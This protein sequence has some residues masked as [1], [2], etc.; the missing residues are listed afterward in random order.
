MVTQGSLVK[1]ECRESV[2]FLALLA[3]LVTLVVLESRV[4]LVGRE[5]KEVL[6]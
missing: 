2:E 1:V 3:D 4:S 6:A 5:V